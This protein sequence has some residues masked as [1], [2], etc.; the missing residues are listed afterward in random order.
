[1][2]KVQRLKLVLESPE[3]RFSVTSNAAVRPLSAVPGEGQK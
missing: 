1:L 3:Q 2:E